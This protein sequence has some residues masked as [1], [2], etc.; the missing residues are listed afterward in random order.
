MKKILV[1]LAIFTLAFGGCKAFKSRDEKNI[2]SQN[3]PLK[4]AFMPAPD[5]N[6]VKENAVKFAD[7]LSKAAN[8]A[9]EPVISPNYVSII[10]GLGSKQI[11]VA[12]LNSLGYLLARDWS[13]AEAVLQFKGED[14][15]SVYKTAIITRT[16]S[17]IASISDLNGK[18]FAYTDPYS[19]SGYLM[20]LSTFEKNGIKPVNTIFAGGFLEVVEMVYNGRVDAGAIYF[21]DHDPDGRIH[22]A[23]VKLVDKYPDM[24][25]KVGVIHVS[26]PFPTS[27]IVFRKDL[28]PE[29][30]EKLVN[31]FKGLGEDKEAI[32]F[33]GMYGTTGFLPTNQENY[34]VIT[35]ALKELGKDIKEVVPGSLDFYRKHVWEHVPEY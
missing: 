14:G 17:G 18:T 15:K 28:L 29:V 24:I 23:R 30:K 7:K 2:G 20:P 19:M 26:D 9:V 6:V 31:A 11:D 35:D 8:F 27:P 25:D 33:L 3:V 32:G 12:L 5:K 4:M 34:N 1:S 16:D 10:D 13:G 21:C 22:D